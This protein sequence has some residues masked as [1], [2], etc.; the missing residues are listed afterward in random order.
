MKNLLFKNSFIPVLFSI[1]VI[2]CRSKDANNYRLFFCDSCEVAVIEQV[3]DMDSV[4]IFFKDYSDLNNI[5]D[6]IMPIDERYLRT[7][8][9]RNFTGDTSIFNHFDGVSLDAYAN[10]LIPDTNIKKENY[11]GFEKAILSLQQ[12]KEVPNQYKREKYIRIS[13]PIFS[14]NN[15][16]VLVEVDYNCF[17]LCGEGFTYVLTKRKNHWILFKKI[18]RWVS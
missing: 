3:F 12:I 14:N 9:T 6:A 8:D 4:K 16:F 18:L 5:T 1:V 2:S 15:T 13:K 11:P 10:A 17:G 7:I